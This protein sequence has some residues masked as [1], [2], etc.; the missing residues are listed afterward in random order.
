VVLKWE[1]AYA[2][3]FRVQISDDPDF[4]TS[5]DLYATSAGTGGTQSIDVSG[6]G[7]YV[8]LHGRTRATPYGISLYEFQVYGR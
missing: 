8:R 7:R 4:R 1:A 5:T 3:S 2:R 6:Q